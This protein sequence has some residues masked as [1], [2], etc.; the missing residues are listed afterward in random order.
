MSPYEDPFPPEPPRAQGEIERLPAGS[1][2]APRT[3]LEGL[4]GYYR[5]IFKGMAVPGLPDPIVI[6]NAIIAQTDAPIRTQRTHIAQLPG[7]RP[8]FVK[9]MEHG[10]EVGRGDCLTVCQLDVVL[11]PGLSRAMRLWRDQA[12]G[13]ISLVVALFDERLAQ[14]ELAEDLLVLDGDGEV[15]ATLDH[16][17]ELR[18]FR[19]VNRV[20]DLHRDLLAG[21]ADTDLTADDPK[22]TAG[23][24]YL[25]AAQLGPTPDA[26]V[27]LWVALEA[28]S[29]AGA[30]GLVGAE[31]PRTDVAWVER[32]LRL[33]GLDPAAVEPSVGRLAGLRADVVH[34]GMEQPDLLRE[35][36][37]A[38]E[39]LARLLLRHATGAGPL[40][41]PLSPD[42][43]N[44]LAFLQPLADRLHARPR[45]I[46]R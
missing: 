21:I 36:Y 17:G 13:A 2:E 39:Q 16:V 8:T 10:V 28:L 12:L 33:A 9:E 11:P 35:G 26:I 4:S 40:G 14:A 23:R 42:Q 20:L 31:R 15:I 44:V 34:Q 22:L 24:W 19:A 3:G 27:F 38:L 1:E 25:R 37:Y 45:T 5:L 18:T 30:D 6:G 7:W 43:S 29:R 41:W 32:A 46:W